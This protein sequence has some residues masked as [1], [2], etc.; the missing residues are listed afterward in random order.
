MGR[1]SL[2][3]ALAITV[4]ACTEMPS[5]WSAA[6]ASPEAR[7]A[8]LGLDTADIERIDV[9]VDRATEGGVISRHAWARLKSCAGY[10]VVRLDTA[11]DW[12]DAYTTGNCRLPGIRS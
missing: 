4:A 12:N 5:R 9:V 3:S 1:T 11:C 2:V 10:I 8:A 7:F 6:C